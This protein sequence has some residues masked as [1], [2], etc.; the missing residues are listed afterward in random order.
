MEPFITFS[1]VLYIRITLRFAATLSNDIEKYMNVPGIRDYVAY[2]G[3]DGPTG[4]CK[5]SNR[6]FLTCNGCSFQWFKEMH[7]Q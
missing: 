7:T 4:A 6:V 2:V 5:S 1:V 3:F